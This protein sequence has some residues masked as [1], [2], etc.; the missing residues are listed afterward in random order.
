M[1]RQGQPLPA[2]VCSRVF[3]VA[4]CGNGQG[5][6]NIPILREAFRLYDCPEAPA[7]PASER[8]AGWCLSGH[9]HPALH[10]AQH[11]SN[12]EALSHDPGASQ[13]ASQGESVMFPLALTVS[14]PGHRVDWVPGKWTHPACLTQLSTLWHSSLLPGRTRGTPSSS[15]IGKH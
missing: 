15:L 2:G 14:T 13:P 9:T 8:G 12:P 6:L 4:R 7:P 10:S 5:L 1:P 3:E 11:C